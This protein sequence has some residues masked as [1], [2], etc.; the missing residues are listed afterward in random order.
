LDDVLHVAE[1]LDVVDDRRAHVEA[2]GGGEV[3]RLDAWVGTL[4]FE[5]LDQ[6]GFLTA[7][8]GGGATVDVDFEIESGA[9]DVLADEMLLFRF[10][11]GLFENDGGFGELFADVD[12]GDVSADGEAR[13]DHALDELVR[14]LVEDVAV[15]ESAGLRFVRV[16]DEVDGLGIV[17]WDEGPLDACWETCSATTAQAGLFDF[18]RDRLGLHAK[19]GL[20][21]LVAAVV[22]VGFNG[23]IPANAINVFEDHAMLARIWLLTFFVWDVAHGGNGWDQVVGTASSWRP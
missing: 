12:V 7:N 14:V 10:G 2:E 19:G 13:D 21:L 20:E 5:R 23:W 16:A 17:R 1:R 4:A 18:F 15:F 3:G 9:E 8:V 11:D 22:E 6:A